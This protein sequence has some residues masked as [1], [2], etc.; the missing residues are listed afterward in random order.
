VVANEVKSWRRKP[1]YRR[2]DR[3][4]IEAI[5]A[6]TK[7]AVSAIAE[8]SSVINRSTTS[9]PPSRGAV[10][11]QTATTNEITRNVSKPPRRGRIAQNI[12]AVAQAAKGTADASQGHAEGIEP[13]RAARLEHA[14]PG[15][16]H[17]Q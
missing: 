4:E 1:P 7:G 2:G 12:T 6:D 11:E 13:A 17:Q 16:P 5:Q 10:E 14:G 8:I 9:R 15:Q 3:P